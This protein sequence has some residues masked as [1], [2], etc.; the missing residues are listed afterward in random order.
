MLTGTCHCGATGWQ[1]EDDPS[2]VTACNCSLCRRFAALWAYGVAQ[3]TVRF[4]GDTKDYER[5]DHGQLT[6][7][8]CPTCSATLG[9]FAV[10]PTAKGVRQAAVNLRMIDDPTPILSFP[11]R[12]FE[13]LHT[14]KSLGHDARTVKDMWF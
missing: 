12:H 3:Q 5:T 11:V 1:F 4:Q 8:H 9:W 2:T 13:G 14:F 7:F 6:F 10:A